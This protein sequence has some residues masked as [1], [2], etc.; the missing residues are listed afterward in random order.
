MTPLRDLATRMS[1]PRSLRALYVQYS[2]PAAYPPIEHSAHILA[3]AG[4]DVL[5]LGT[6]V[7]DGSLAFEPHERILVRL[8]AFRGGGIGQKIH[9]VMFLLWAAGIATRWRPDW[10][11]ASDPLSSPIALVLLLLTGARV[12]Y[13]EHDSP[14]LPARARPTL[15]MRAVLAMRGQL[16]RRATICVLPNYERAR[17]F[18]RATGR[19]DSLIVWNCPMRADITPVP[20]RSAGGALRIFYHG[21]IVPARLPLA[22]VEALS[23]VPRTVSLTFAG[24][25]T[26][27]HPGYIAALQSEAVRCGVGDRVRYL[28]TVPA[29][30][31]LMRACAE[32]DVGLSL[33]PSS[34]DD[35]NEDA[36]VGASNKVFDYL[37]SGLAVLVSDRPD[38]RDTFVA[39]GFGL[40]CNPASPESIA[41]ALLAWLVRPSERE[42]MADRGRRRI[43]SEWNYETAFAPILRR[44]MAPSLSAPGADRVATI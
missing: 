29:R 23:K 25:E 24:Y 9:Y 35:P 42:A 6:N 37:A 20:S 31:D 3:D 18:G 16:A 4:F 26:P 7:L 12:V 14:G 27:G 15:F 32:C 43:A 8:R 38:W 2:N 17:A 11:Y 1:R 21:S 5:L 39:G 41:A 40:A 30:R 36:M 22:V 10:I 19:P 13:H 34:T 33:L 44:M 28:G